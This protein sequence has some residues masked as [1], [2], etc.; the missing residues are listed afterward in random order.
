MEDLKENE[1]EKFGSENFEVAIKPEN[2]NFWFDIS[3]KL[4]LLKMCLISLIKIPFN[5][6]L[7]ITEVGLPS[8]KFYRIYKK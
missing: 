6:Q 8:P 4:N 2:F 1:T 5:K 3:S 7:S